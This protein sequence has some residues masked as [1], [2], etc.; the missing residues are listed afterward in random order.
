[1]DTPISK[2]YFFGNSNLYLKSW[3]NSISGFVRGIFAFRVTKEK[4]SSL[5]TGP[6]HFSLPLKWCSF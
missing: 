5:K 3:Y 2:K 4:M 6:S 1:M